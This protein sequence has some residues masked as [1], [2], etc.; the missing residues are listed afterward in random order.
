MLDLSSVYAKAG[1]FITYTLWNQLRALIQDKF[2]AGIES[3]DIAAGGVANSNLANKYAPI[4][5]VDRITPPGLDNFD[6]GA[7]AGA[8]YQGTVPPDLKIAVFD[9]YAENLTMYR[10]PRDFTLEAV[11]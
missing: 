7:H 2:T 1:Q 11:W 3:A 8:W 10:A 5:C 9:G 4:S 6:A